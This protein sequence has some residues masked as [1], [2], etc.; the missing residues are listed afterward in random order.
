MFK[1][2]VLICGF[3]VAAMHFCNAQTTVYAYIKDEKGKP[4]ER[5]EVDMKGS[6]ENMTADKIG[7]FQFVDLKPG[8]YQI[9]V[10]KNN[11]DTKTLWDCCS[12]R[13]IFSIESQGMIWEFTGSAREVWTAGLGK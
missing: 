6:E 13:R 10:F 4:V 8:K 1:K 2:S 5:A 7:Y 12:L 3:T 11:Y 9:V